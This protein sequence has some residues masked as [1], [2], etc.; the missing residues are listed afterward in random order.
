[1][2]KST[3][4]MMSYGCH[5]QEIV[6]TN[7]TYNQNGQKL[8]DQASPGMEI[9]RGWKRGK[10]YISKIGLQNNYCCEPCTI[11]FSFVGQEKIMKCKMVILDYR[12]RDILRYDWAGPTG[13][14]PLGVMQHLVHQRISSLVLRIDTWL[15][16]AVFAY[17][18]LGYPTAH[19][20]PIT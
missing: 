2:R 11:V 17:L 18:T 4:M 20:L 12:G 19:A 9:W 3:I 1:M 10:R 15:W 13:V 6:D 7:R 5:N 8:P 16:S 14:I